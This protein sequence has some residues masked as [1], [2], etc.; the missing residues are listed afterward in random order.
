MLT[1]TCKD[2]IKFVARRLQ[3]S[4]VTWDSLAGKASQ[5]VPSATE[6]LKISAVL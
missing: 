1:I 3:W 4:C 6:V 5:R 2:D